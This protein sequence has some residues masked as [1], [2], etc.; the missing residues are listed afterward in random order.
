MRLFQGTMQFLILDT[1]TLK[2]MIANKL[3]Q[4]L[5]SEG[6]HIDIPNGTTHVLP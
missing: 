3:L 6:A 5:Q 2:A 1:E 4:H